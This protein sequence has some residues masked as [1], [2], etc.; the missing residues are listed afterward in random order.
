[1]AMSLTF[2]EIDCI[3][4]TCYSMNFLQMLSDCVQVALYT[5]FILHRRLLYQYNLRS[6]I[7]DELVVSR[8]KI[9]F[10]DR[11]FSMSGPATWN[12]LPYYIR[13]ASLVDIFKSKLK[14]YL[15][16]FNITDNLLL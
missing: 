6:D 2:L 16:D 11:S 12:A 8:T 10:G 15:F 13:D 9:K 7:H 1:M 14:T 5:S 4:V 3:L